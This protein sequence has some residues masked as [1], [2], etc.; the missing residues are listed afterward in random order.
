M[1]WITTTNGLIAL[2]TG[3]FGLIGTGIAT[4][5]AIRNWISKIKNKSALDHWNT[6]MMAADAAMQAAEASSLAGPDK[7][8]MVISMVKAS[9]AAAGLDIGPFVDQLSA[10]IDQC[11]EFYNGMNSAN[12]VSH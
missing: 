4:Y 8:E 10:Y 7:K 1:D 9:C 11:I 5:F 3:L 12:K 2:L 6:V